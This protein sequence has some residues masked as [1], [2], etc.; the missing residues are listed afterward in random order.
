MLWRI[1][2]INGDG[3]IRLILKEKIDTE[4]MFNYYVWQRGVD[5]GKY[6][7]YTYD[8][9][10]HNCTKE[11]PC[12]V[13]YNSDD[14]SNEDFGGQNSDIK[15]TLETWYKNNL[16]GYNEKIAQ[17]YFCNDV[18][19][20]SGNED[21]TIDEFLNY[22]AYERIK[23]RYQP[24][25]KCPNPTKQDGSLRDYG[26]IYKTKI[27]LI[28]ADEM[29]LGGLSQNKPYADKTNYLYHNNYFWMSL[30]PDHSRYDAFVYGSRS[31]Q[32]GFN[33]TWYHLAV[34]PVINL[35]PNVQ[36]TGEGTKEGPYQIIES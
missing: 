16:N 2:R 10:I 31:G 33:L 32:V 18:S 6:T 34:V 30:S 29:N 4:S 9:K 35:K 36:V 5:V 13:I 1:V 25:L 3:S 20:G 22:G 7:G 14:F 11:N 19:Y 8:N 28:T 17:G 21:A 12:E 23:N 26:G 15:T 27:G 24:S